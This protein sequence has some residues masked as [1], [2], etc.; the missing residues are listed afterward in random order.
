MTH[1]MGDADNTV[2]RLRALFALWVCL[3]ILQA[4]ARLETHEVQ[5]A[6]LAERLREMP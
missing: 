3:A 1:P 6:D 5:I 2:R 4:A